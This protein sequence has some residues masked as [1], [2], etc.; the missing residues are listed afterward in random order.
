[1]EA[2]HLYYKYRP[3][4]KESALLEY[5]SRY[6]GESRLAISSSP[7]SSYVNS[8]SH[9]FFHREVRSFDLPVPYGLSLNQKPAKRVQI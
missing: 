4:E 3:N 8:L 9:L 7:D 1:I 2:S 6:V 5:H